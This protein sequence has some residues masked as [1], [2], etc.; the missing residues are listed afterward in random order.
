MASSSTATAHAVA[1]PET[2]TLDG[3]SAALDFDAIYESHSRAIYYLALRLLGDATR[4]EDAAQ[5]VFVKAFRNMAGFRHGS[6]IRTWL[7]RI[8]INHCQ[9]LRQAWHQRN[10]Q[11]TEDGTFEN[12]TDTNRE[13][14]LRIAELKDLGAQIQKC[15]DSIPPEYRLLIL[16]VADSQLTYEQVAALTE[17]SCDS[18]RGKL[19][20]ARRAFAAV[21]NKTS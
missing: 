13:T 4:A 7:F 21:F 2:R 8:T 11:T 5:D 16:L 14:P 1:P 19:Y 12:G 20:R 15:L 10:I 18:V 17:Q 9:N 3:K 6:E